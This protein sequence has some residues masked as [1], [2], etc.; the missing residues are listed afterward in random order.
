MLSNITKTLQFYEVDQFYC[1]NVHSFASY[2]YFNIV[3]CGQMFANYISINIADIFIH[4]MMQFRLTVILPVSNG[5]IP[6]V[7]SLF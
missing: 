4:L 3:A 6:F 2:Q 7:I 1:S 5:L